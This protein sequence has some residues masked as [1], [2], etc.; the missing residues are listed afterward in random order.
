MFITE[1]MIKATDGRFF[2]IY[3]TNSKGEKS[4]YIVRTG[5]KKG[6]KGGKNYCPSDAVTLYA[7]SKDGKREMG[8]RTMYIDKIQF[9]N[10]PKMK[11]RNA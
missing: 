5:V 3:Y 4:K 10:I 2:S 8:F 6:L 11:P 9:L 1:L 7:V